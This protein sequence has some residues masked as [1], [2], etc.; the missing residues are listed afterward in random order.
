MPRSPSVKSDHRQA[1][2]AAGLVFPSPALPG[3]R[4]VAFE[5]RCDPWLHIILVELVLD[6][7][8]RAPARRPSVSGSGPLFS[9]GAAG[10]RIGEEKKVNLRHTAALALTGWYL[11]V[12]LLGKIQTPLPA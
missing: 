12:S 11:M 4:A 2:G 6:R 10:S 7:V 5:R 3:P 9:L 8:N 1:V